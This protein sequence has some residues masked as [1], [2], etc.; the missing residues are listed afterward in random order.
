MASAASSSDVAVAAHRDE[1]GR[2]QRPAQLRREPL[3]PLRTAAGGSSPHNASISCSA[4]TTRPALQRQHREQRPQ[5]RPR[6]DDVSA[7]VIEHLEPTEQPDPHR[8]TVPVTPHL[9]GVISLSSARRW[10]LRS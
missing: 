4:G 10:T 8:F 9:Q 6:D 5:L 7:V 3:K 1:V 2:T